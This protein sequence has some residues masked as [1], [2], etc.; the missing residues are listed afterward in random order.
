MRGV[1]HNN[2]WVLKIHVGVYRKLRESGAT[3]KCK[4]FPEI[5]LEAYSEFTQTS[6]IE[7]FKNR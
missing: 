2:D 6:K 1:H 3:N 5:I 4:K 7:L